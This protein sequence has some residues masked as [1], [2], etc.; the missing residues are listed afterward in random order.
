M[1]VLLRSTITKLCFLGTDQWTTDP[2]QA[3]DFEHV[4]DAAR[5]DRE[6]QMAGMEVV[7]RFADHM[8]DVV[9]PL[10]KP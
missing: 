9:L 10:R 2:N 6:Q 8:Y 5:F 1:K 4:H 7:L 3:R